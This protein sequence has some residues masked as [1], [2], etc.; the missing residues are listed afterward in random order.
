MEITTADDDTKYLKQFQ[1]HSP[2]PDGAPCHC[3]ECMHAHAVRG[4]AAAMTRIA[5]LNLGLS[6][7]EADRAACYRLNGMEMEDA[8]R[9]AKRNETTN[10]KTVAI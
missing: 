7:G 2:W 8:I 1:Y 3:E 6:Q 10:F 9:N 5:A 4:T